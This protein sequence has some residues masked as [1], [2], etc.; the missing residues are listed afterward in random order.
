MNLRTGYD[1]VT[2]CQFMLSSGCCPISVICHNF[3]HLVKNM[4]TIICTRLQ[5]CNL[6]DNNIFCQRCNRNKWLALWPVMSS[7]RFYFYLSNLTSYLQLKDSSYPRS[8]I[9]KHAISGKLVHMNFELSSF[10]VTANIHVIIDYPH[11]PSVP[12]LTQGLCIVR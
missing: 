4:C 2:R 10:L 5:N 8:F 1:P 7:R 11:T 3:K 6:F 12:S 9:I